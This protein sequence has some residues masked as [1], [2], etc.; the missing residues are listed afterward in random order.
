MRIISSRRDADTATLSSF[1]SEQLTD[2]IDLINHELGAPTVVH[3][4]F[5]EKTVEDLGESV[6]NLLV[7]FNELQS[8]HAVAMN[9]YINMAISVDLANKELK[10]VNAK[11]DYIAGNITITDSDFDGAVTRLLT[12]LNAKPIVTINDPTQAVWSVEGSEVLLKNAL[13]EFFVDLNVIKMS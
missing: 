6:V 12:D 3:T 11:L 5:I 1:V 8:Q 13:L 4:P 9:D 7:A 2:M 10:A